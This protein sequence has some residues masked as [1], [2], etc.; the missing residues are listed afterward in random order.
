MTLH[1][2]Q[3][4]ISREGEQIVVHIPMTL[5]VRGGRKEILLPEGIVSDDS[6]AHRS[7]TASP[8]LIALARGFR[9]KRFLETGRFA[10]IG[11]LAIAVGRDSSYVGRTLNLT[12][13][14][15]DIIQAI[16]HGEEPSGLS[17]E[18]L[19]KFPQEWEEQREAM[20]LSVILLDE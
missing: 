6:P 4:T 9:W 15:P 18:K 12:L 19:K 3:M 1:V 20:N 16:L 13:L 10:S 2:D 7:T 8:L 17:L 14:A 5:K 11:E